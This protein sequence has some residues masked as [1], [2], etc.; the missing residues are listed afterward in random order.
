[1]PKHDEPKKR[2][3]EGDE[4]YVPVVELAADTL[5]GDV[6]DSIMSFFTAQ[7]KSWP[8]MSEAERKDFARALDRYSYELVKQ[9]CTI[10][11]TGE[12]PS[13]VGVLK[14]YREKEGVEAKLKFPSTE[15]V[16]TSLHEACGQDVLVVTSGFELFSGEQKEADEIV[17]PDQGKLGIGEE[18]Q[19]Q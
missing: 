6:R 8:F 16:V 3:S 13:I 14:E 17:P 12:R 5:R 18:Y 15:N 2:A 11:A 9:A 19:E 1:M 7:P 4:D 10:I